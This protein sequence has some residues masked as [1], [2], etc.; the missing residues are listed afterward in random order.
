VCGVC[1]CVYMRLCVWVCVIMPS[2][3]NLYHFMFGFCIGFGVFELFHD[4]IAIKRLCALCAV[5]LYVCVCVCV[6]M[7]MCV[8][9]CVYVYV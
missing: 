3:Q 6:C 7:C 2:L 8:C 5:L 4:L 1:V 9:V